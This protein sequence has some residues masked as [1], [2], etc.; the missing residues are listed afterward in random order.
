VNDSLICVVTL[1]SGLP[2]IRFHGGGFGLVVLSLFLQDPSTMTHWASPGTIG[3]LALVYTTPGTHSIS[4]AFV[5]VV[6]CGY[7]LVLISSMLLTCCVV[8]CSV[9]YVACSRECSGLPLLSW[10]LRSGLPLLC[11]V[12]DCLFWVRHPACASASKGPAASAGS[13]GGDSA[14][15]NAGRRSRH[16]EESAGIHCLELVSAVAG[17]AKIEADAAGFSSSGQASVG[18]LWG[19]R[20]SNFSI[21]C[22]SI[23]Q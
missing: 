10:V 16:F 14:A 3:D 9:P 23:I 19:W 4:L 7:C 2:L 1:S 20:S 18:W 15:P 22:L 21:L 5:S 6:A 11:C 12:P 8:E 17:A 13:A